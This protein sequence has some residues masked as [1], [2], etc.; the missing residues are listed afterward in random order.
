LIH[1]VIE[2]KIAIQGIKMSKGVKPLLVT[3]QEAIALPKA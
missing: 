1:Y 2:Q 3:K